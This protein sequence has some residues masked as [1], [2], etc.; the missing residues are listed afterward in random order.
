M[1]YQEIL[2]L[3]S[4]TMNTTIANSSSDSK[5]PDQWERLNETKKEE[6][7]WNVQY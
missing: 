4:K 2:I 1:C 6:T 3:D 7:L 5:K